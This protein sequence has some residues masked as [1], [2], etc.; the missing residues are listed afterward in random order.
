MSITQFIERCDRFCEKAGVSRT[1]L[2]KRLL[3]DTYRLELLA[4]GSVD[5]GVKRLSRAVADL[6]ELEAAKPSREEAAA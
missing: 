4:A 3:H 1:W 2:S 6:E 5:I